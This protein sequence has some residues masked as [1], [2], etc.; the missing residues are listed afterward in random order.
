MA[1]LKLER[2]GVAFRAGGR[3]IRAL[4]GVDLELEEGQTSV[5]VGP[6]GSGKTTLLRVAA[7]LLEPQSGRVAM[8]AGTKLGFVFQEPRLL[9]HLTAEGNIALGLGSR[10]AEREGKLRVA[11][12]VELLGLA[13]HRRAFPSEL[14]GGLAQ[15]VALGRALVREP[16]VV[17]MDEPFSAL[18]APLRRRLQDE[19]LAI[20]VSRRTSALFVTH[21]LVEALYIGDR[22]IALRDG[23]LVRD[24]AID[25]PRPREPRSVD[26]AGLQDSL[27]LTLGS[28]RSAAR[29]GG[30][31]LE[32]Q[33]RFK[34]YSA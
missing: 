22:V 1:R 20:L 27:S 8:A 5:I 34:E 30:A 26:F 28:A 24:E 33:T 17:F 14:S 25:L 13:S 32:Y 31:E 12:T 18:D 3:E 6:S 21:D 9:G 29:N 23:R 10:R 15:R 16:D 2:V 19:L 11:E 7:G 4:D